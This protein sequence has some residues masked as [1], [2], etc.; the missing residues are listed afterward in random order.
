MKYNRFNYVAPEINVFL[1]EV[2]RGFEL[3][4][5]DFEQP[6]YGGEDNL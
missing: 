2:E 3:S 6:N 4:G 5:D 1:I